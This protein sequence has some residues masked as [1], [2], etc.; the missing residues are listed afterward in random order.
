MDKNGNN[1]QV[2]HSKKMVKG[3]GSSRKM[4]KGVDVCVQTKKTK[5]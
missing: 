3:I 5:G 2:K 4:S 1:K